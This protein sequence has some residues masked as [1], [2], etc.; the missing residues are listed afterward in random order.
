MSK[1]KKLILLGVFLLLVLILLSFKER[2]VV[3]FDSKIAGLEISQVPSISLLPSQI[4]DA[5]I[6]TQISL[7]I[8]PS[9][10]EIVDENEE[11]KNEDLYLVEKVIDGDTIRLEGGLVVRYIG[12]DTP[13]AVDPRKPVQCFAK[14]A[15]EK[16][17]ELVEGKLVSLEKDISE[18]D[19]YGRLLR[20]VYSGDGMV[21]EILVR[22]GFAYSYSYP[23]DVKN[24]ELFR[25]A[26]E[27]ARENNRGLWGAVCSV[28]NQSQNQ[29]TTVSSGKYVCDCSK[30]CSKIASCEEAQYQ[31]TVCGCTA[32]DGDGDGLACE[33][34]CQ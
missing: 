30:S 23:P 34:S 10:I 13:E 7:D 11:T 1:R 19:R 25:Q 12:I 3:K 15:S 32:R 2:S 17:R 27:E 28:E 33:S 9:E 31:L 4:I 16:N 6:T 20:Y 24:Q 5:Q 14:E 26:E 8:I 21:N 29:P 18:T 22:E